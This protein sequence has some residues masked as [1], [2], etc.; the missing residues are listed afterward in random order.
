MH[1]STTLFV[2]RKVRFEGRWH[3]RCIDC[4]IGKRVEDA[5]F[6]ELSLRNNGREY[7]V[8]LPLEECETSGI[9]LGPLSVYGIDE[10][11]KSAAIEDRLALVAAQNSVVV[12]TEDDCN[13]LEP[14]TFL[15][16]EECCSVRTTHR[17]HFELVAVDE[18]P[19]C[20]RELS[21][22]EDDKLF[23]NAA[24]TSIVSLPTM[25]PLPGSLN[26]DG[27]DVPVVYQV[28]EWISNH[29]AHID[30]FIC[31]GYQELVDGQILQRK[32]RLRNGA[33]V[34]VEIGKI[35]SSV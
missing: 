34:I 9:P 1:S 23:E 20:L 22:D 24:G 19:D 16:S 26:L 5:C 27:L 10:L 35:D 17:I 33:A 3:L 11:I 25:L 18:L 14:Y 29:Q 2:I 13:E 7:H 31:G 32:A 30:L 28:R 21:V 4:C 6:G 8:K 15:S 12:V